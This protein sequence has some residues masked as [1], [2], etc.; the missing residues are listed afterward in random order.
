MA[1]SGLLAFAF[2][3]AVR[4]TRG[5]RDA[6]AAQWTALAPEIHTLE[7][8]HPKVL[9]LTVTL[10]PCRMLYGPGGM[11]RGVQQQT[12]PVGARVTRSPRAAG[13]PELREA[14]RQL[15]RC[16]RRRAR[17][18]A[19]ACR[20]QRDASHAAS[21][22]RASGA[23]GHWYREHSVAL[24]G[25]YGIGIWYRAQ[26]CVCRNAALCRATRPCGVGPCL[27]KPAGPQAP[28]CAHACRGEAPQA[29]SGSRE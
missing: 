27:G 12:R 25:H 26:R 23:A 9:G 18:A 19:G 13:G 24:S 5:T 4:R 29:S 21:A 11:L 14:G 3:A 20:A 6:A 7:L 15:A 10:H 1:S 22:T 16:H 17:A 2:W 8:E 28:L